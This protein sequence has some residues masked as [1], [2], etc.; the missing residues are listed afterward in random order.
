MI[1]VHMPYSELR[2][3]TLHIQAASPDIASGM[4]GHDQLNREGKQGR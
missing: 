1:M 4:T 3:L 2:W